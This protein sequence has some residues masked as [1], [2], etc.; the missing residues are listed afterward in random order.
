M[1]LGLRALLDRAVAHMSF[2]SAFDEIFRRYG[3][4]TVHPIRRQSQSARRPGFVSRSMR[5]G[6][7]FS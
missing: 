4:L 1:S 5:S 6:G 7:A 3:G 2:A